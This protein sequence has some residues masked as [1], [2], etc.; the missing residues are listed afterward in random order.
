MTSALSNDDEC[1]ETDRC[2]RDPL[3]AAEDEYEIYKLLTVGVMTENV[4]KDI[5]EWDKIGQRMLVK[6]TTDNLKRDDFVCGTKWQRRISKHS[7]HQMP[8]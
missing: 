2:V 4:S 3:V 6:F 5:L 7:K 8:W 1:S